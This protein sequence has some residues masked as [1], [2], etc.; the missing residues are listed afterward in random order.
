[1]DHDR[2]NSS[3]C[4][5]D[6]VSASVK[7]FLVSGRLGAVSL[8]VA[9]MMIGQSLGLSCAAA[10]PAGTQRGFALIWSP[11]YNGPQIAQSLGEMANVGANS[12]QFTPAWGQQ[13]TNASAIARTSVTM[14]DDNLERA[15]ALAHNH[16]LKVLLTPHVNVPNDSRSAIRP[17]DRE[18]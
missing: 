2:L 9:A 18:A 14:S 16:G 7:A 6:S 1:M 12:V 5:D 15:I 11:F 10:E 13:A 4:G 17:D 3:T 8:L